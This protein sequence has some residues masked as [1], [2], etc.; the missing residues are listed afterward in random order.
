VPKRNQDLTADCV[1]PG[2]SVD[3]LR[4]GFCEI[5]RNPICKH[6]QAEP[7]A[8]NW[9]DRINTQED[10]LLNNPT[11]A[12]Q[13]FEDIRALDFPSLLRESIRIHKAEAR[14]DW[15][16]DPKHRLADAQRIIV[17]EGFTKEPTLAKPPEVVA[18]VE[19]EPPA[20]NPYRIIGVVHNKAGADTPTQVAPPPAT[21]AIAPT[22]PLKNT[23][24]PSQG[25][26]IGGDP[27]PSKQS[28]NDG[29]S[30][31]TGPRDKVVSVGAKIKMG[32]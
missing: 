14:G 29:W 31:P 12:T 6:A 19:V 20:V 15:G 5:C 8:A 11:I 7:A 2:V 4:R 30:L 22:A 23:A 17:P 27:S 25:I 10:R 9:L 24:V 13:G 16:I 1:T 26:M 32:S 3:D 18:P 21:P 28:A